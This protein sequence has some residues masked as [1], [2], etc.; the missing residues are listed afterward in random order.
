MSFTTWINTLLGCYQPAPIKSLHYLVCWTAI[1]SNCEDNWERP[2]TLGHPDVQMAGSH[3]N[4][5]GWCVCVFVCVCIHPPTSRVVSGVFSGAVVLTA[6]VDNWFRPRFQ[7]SHSISLFTVQSFRR[8]LLFRLTRGEYRLM[9]EEI[10]GQVIALKDPCR[11]AGDIRGWN[12]G[13]EP[14]NHYNILPL[15]CQD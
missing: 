13:M 2:I 12:R 1:P 8:R 6:A 7:Q 14:T 9:W 10:E 4:K 3:L 15:F 5:G 11:S